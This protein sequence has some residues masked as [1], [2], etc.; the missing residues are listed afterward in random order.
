MNNKPNS[1]SKYYIAYF[2][3]LGY[4]E[5]FNENPNR[6]ENFLNVI[7]EAINEKVLKNMFGQWRITTIY[8]I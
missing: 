1:M 6:I 3:I 2:D 7:N 8:A 4:R 5:Y